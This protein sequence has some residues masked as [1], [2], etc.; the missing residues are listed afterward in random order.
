MLVHRAWRRLVPA[1]GPKDTPTKGP[2]MVDAR[3]D[4]PWPRVR[5]P[6]LETLKEGV[7]RDEPLD[8]NDSNFV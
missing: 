4:G 7:L 5:T 1:N 8:G 3:S 6:R 2:P